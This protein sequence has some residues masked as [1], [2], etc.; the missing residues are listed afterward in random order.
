MQNETPE[1]LFRLEEKISEARSRFPA[2]DLNGSDCRWCGIGK[3]LDGNG[4]VRC[5]HCDDPHDFST[6]GICRPIFVNA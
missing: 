6:C 2:A 1:Y 5:I 4:A 3:Y